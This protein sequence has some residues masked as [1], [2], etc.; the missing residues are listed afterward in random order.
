[1]TA[2]TATPTPT[3]DPLHLRADRTARAAS[4][5]AATVSG[6]LVAFE[7]ALAA[8]APWGA[9]AWG[10]THDGVLPT[11]L[12]VASAAG[13]AVWSGAALVALRQGGWRTPAPLPARR[14]RLATGLL[15]GYAGVGTLMNLVSRSD[16]ERALW[17]PTALVLAVSL[18]VTAARG[19]GPVGTHR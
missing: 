14:L 9:A 16:V 3:P 5:V 13:A 18:A 19:R 7:V 1:M 4:M 17:T 12:R 15:A 6:V 11:G 10:G 8:G 2:S